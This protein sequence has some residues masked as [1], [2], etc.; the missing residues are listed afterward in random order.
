MK[1]KT[2]KDLM[3]PLEDYATVSEEATLYDAVTA[4]EN[5][6]EKFNRTTHRYMHRAI[7]VLD[8]NQDVVGKISQLD[9]LKALEPRYGKLEDNG[10]LSR[11]GYSPEFLKSMIQEHALWVH[12]LRDICSKAAKVKVKDFMY[13]PTEDE[14]VDEDVSLEE[15]IHILIMGYHHSLLV[16]K[17]GKILGILRLTDV[18][19]AISDLIRTCEF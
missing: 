19:V 4:L 17:D 12:P 13:T 7:L 2:V 16:T 6:Q 5:A 10:M 11:A 3:V 15:A 1:S 18:F 9:V 8:R 14:Y